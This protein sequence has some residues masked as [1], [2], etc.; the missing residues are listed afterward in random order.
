MRS[1]PFP[2]APV[3]GFW[4]ALGFLT[5][6]PVPEREAERG[7]ATATIF[8][9]WIGLG[10]G[11]L[12]ALVARMPVDP[13]VAGSLALATHFFVT[14]GLHWDGWADVL[15]A[16]LGPALSREKRVSILADPRIGAHAAVGVALLAVLAVSALA[17]APFW[18]IV[19][20][21]VTGR[22]VMVASLRWAPALRSSGA[23]AGLRAHA[24]PVGA[25]VG[26]AAVVALCLVRA[27]APGSL[28][29][30]F[31][32]GVVVAAAFATF[33]VR[34]LGGMNG[35]AHGAVGLLAETVVWLVAAETT[36]GTA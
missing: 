10:L 7:S 1:G 26:L 23:A 28:A 2:G 31:G 9:P 35:D 33:L 11:A 27:V 17:R 34:R 6:L 14:G 24:R 4:A 13:L 22:W 36:G 8:F 5:I 19:L 16:T 32:V 20:G 18:G 29:V 15:D 25:G 30:A 12:A 3:A 21:A